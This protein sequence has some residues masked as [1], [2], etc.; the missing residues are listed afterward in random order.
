[1]KKV[2]FCL[3]TMVLGGVE[4]EL[5][6]ILKRFDLNE[7][8]ITVLLLYIDDNDIIKQIPSNISLV[9]LNIDKNYY[10][11]RLFDICKLRFKD[12]KSKEA[13]S[14]IVKRLLNIGMTH[15][16]TDINSLP[17]IKEN[18]DFAICYHMHSPLALKY[19]ATK[20]LADK[21]IAWIHNDFRTTKYKINCLTNILDSYQEFVAVSKRVA[22]E[23]CE[24]CPK[25]KD[26]V[27]IAYNILPVEEVIRKA[28]EI[29]FDSV[30]MNEYKT[31]LLTIGRF[32]KQKGIEYVIECSSLLKK[33][34]KPFHWY[35]I[36]YGELEGFYRKMIRKYNIED[37]FT[38]LGKKENPYPY[39]KKCDIYVQPSIHEADCISVKEA[40]IF[41]KP[42]VCTDFD[43]ADEQII[44][45]EN[46]VIVPVRDVAALE[47]QIEHLIESSEARNKLSNALQNTV[48]VDEWE[49]IIAHFI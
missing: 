27:S 10:C 47:K 4:K 2:V 21:K 31:K 28:D 24:L 38:I 34:G 15:S 6:T 11:S 1:M 13:L 17:D 39:L 32:T 5:I 7:Y 35:L 41:C 23:F 33:K 16:N 14:L 29:I 3:Q 18:F 42:I 20:I 48:V 46:G 49:D 9:S 45:E 44:N 25:Y 12:G 22:E 36:G 30:F 8:D 37:C 43:G 19:V 26:K 40:K